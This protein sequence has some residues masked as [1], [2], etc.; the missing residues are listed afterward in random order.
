[1]MIKC[2]ATNCQD[3]SP[4]RYKDQ[5]IAFFHTHYSRLCIKNHPDLSKSYV[6]DFLGESPHLIILNDE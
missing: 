4:S 1:M 2:L 3:I 6:I 5:K